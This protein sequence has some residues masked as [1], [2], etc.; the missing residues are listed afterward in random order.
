[1]LFAVICGVAFLTLGVCFRGR[2]CVSASQYSRAALGHN[3]GGHLD[4]DTELDE[5]S[6]LTTALPGRP[7]P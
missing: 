7:N 5:Y 4:G 2:C 3:G 1:M 6:S